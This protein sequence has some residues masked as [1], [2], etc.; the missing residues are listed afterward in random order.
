VVYT[1]H[2][3]FGSFRLSQQA[4]LFPIVASFHHVVFCSNAARDSAPRALR[5]LGRG[6]L[7]V[8]QNGLD[9]GRVRRAL[10]S[11]PPSPADH[12]FTVVWVGRLIPRKD[13]LVALRAFARACGDAG[14]M[15]FVGDGALR[16]DVLQEASRLGV[17]SRVTVTGLV[18]R[19]DVYRH[20]AAAD[21]FVSL[22]WNEGLPVGVL[23]A[24]ACGVPVVLSDI[25]PHRE[26]APRDLAPLVPPGD[27]DALARELESLRG[28]SPEARAD[29]GARGRQLVEEQFSL[30]AMHKGYAAV[31]ARAA[32]EAPHGTKPL[33]RK[34]SV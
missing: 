4:M 23:E 28:M 5:A 33:G 17:G 29:L 12:E 30:E 26:I 24:M 7:A 34:E 21:V 20:V 9:T 27:V 11:A 2:N 32:H 31:Y 6:K 19:E 13:P 8:V 25:A 18:D 22:S 1:V 15:V 14:R 3:S 10:S 16:G